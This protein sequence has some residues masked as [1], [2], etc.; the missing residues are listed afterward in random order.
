MVN[1]VNQATFYI[2]PMLGKNPDQYPR[3]RDC[4][5]GKANNSDTEVDQFGIP[6]KENNIKE[7]FITIYT[8]TGGGNREGYDKENDEMTKMPEYVSDYDD[9]FDCTFAYW[10]FKVPERFLVDYDILTNEKNG[11]GI[12]DT[13]EEY[14]QQ[15]LKVYPKIADKLKEVLY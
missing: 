1:G 15:V 4:W 10:I 12:K 7:P 14:K 13:S 3:F 2:L 6:K 11:K 8:R 9:D 5:A